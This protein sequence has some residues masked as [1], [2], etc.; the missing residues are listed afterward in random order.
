MSEQIKFEKL[1]AQVKQPLV[2]KGDLS[3]WGGT[4]SESALL[5]FIKGWPLKRMPYRIWEY[6]D[7][8]Q[9]ERGGLPS[10]E[11]IVLLERGRLFGEDGESGKGGDLELRRDGDSFRWRF[12]GKIGKDE[13]APL[14]GCDARDFWET[15]DDVAF[16]CYRE[17]ALLWGK[18]DGDRWHD[19]RVAAADLRYPVG[20]GEGAP[21]RVQVE[22]K[23]YSRAGRVQFVWLTKLSE[24]K[25]END[26]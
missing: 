1:L 19:D 23:V 11:D 25:E 22:Y 6:A 2:G 17:T 12:I 10:Q 8:I 4:C 21:E 5:D 14:E 20:D 16:H 13:T 26:G 18:H 24:W 3:I 15:H 9:F 7:R